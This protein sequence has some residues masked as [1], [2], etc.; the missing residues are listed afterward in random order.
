MG[1]A[2]FVKPLNRIRLFLLG[3]AALLS[4]SAAS[5]AS[6]EAPEESGLRQVADKIYVSHEMSPDQVERI[7]ELVKLARKQVAQFYG[8]LLASPKIVFCATAECY[9]DFGAVGLGFTDGSNL[10]ISPQGLRVAIV[11]HELAHVEFAARAG[12]FRKV[13]DEVPQWF[14]EGQAVLISQAEEFS[15]AAWRE[16]TA[17]GRNAP[18]LSALGAMDDWNRLTGAQGEHMQFTYGTA[19]REMERWVILA[20]PDGLRKLA[21]AL[22][23]GEQFEHA[24][25]RIGKNQDLATTIPSDDIQAIG[26]LKAASPGV[27]RGVLIRAAW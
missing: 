25:A 18:P 5:A 13:L 6:L 23:E 7:L 22:H 8:E 9:C 14:D 15:D 26:T 27:A 19:R 17:N 2:I 12:G 4:I 24:Y 16:A 3:A 11:A 10:V 20:G 1:L 21:Q